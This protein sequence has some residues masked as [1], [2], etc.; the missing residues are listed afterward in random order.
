M[1]GRHQASSLWTRGARHC[2][3]GPGLAGV[4]TPTSS[5]KALTLDESQLVSAM[6]SVGI[7]Y[8]H[9]LTS[10]KYIGAG[11][12]ANT[13]TVNAGI[14]GAQSA[15]WRADRRMQGAIRCIRSKSDMRH[16]VVQRQWKP[17]VGRIEK[18]L[19]E[20]V[21]APAATSLARARWFICLGISSRPAIVNNPSGEAS[22]SS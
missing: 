11:L 22:T 18:R 3:A 5:G 15:R 6:V 12:P 4:R 8:R 14:T 19:S 17:N 10:P 2:G 1:A 9:R 21:S 20:Y 13:F 7:P 16:P